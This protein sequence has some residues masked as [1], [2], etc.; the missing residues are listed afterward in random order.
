[1][2]GFVKRVQCGWG[3]AILL[4]FSSLCGCRGEPATREECRVIFDRVVDL[5]LGEM[6]Y[7]DPVLAAR[8]K[9]ELA[10]RLER[11]LEQC[12]GRRMPARALECVKVAKSAEEVSHR[13]LH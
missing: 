4:A 8:K 9:E 11:D 2:R 5:E 10:R 1:M 12:V 13:C 7:R 3:I 6:G